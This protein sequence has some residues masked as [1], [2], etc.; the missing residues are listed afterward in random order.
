MC[1]LRK[2][3]IFTLAAD[4]T[5]LNLRPL[6]STPVRHKRRG[7]RALSFNET[8]VRKHHVKSAK[9]WLAART[10]A[11]A[12]RRLS[13]SGV[14]QPSHGKDRVILRAE[15]CRRVVRSNLFR[16]RTKSDNS[17]PTCWASWS[18]Q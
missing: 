13:D 11:S 7:H 10:Q 18:D 9:A 16:V 4:R 14:M 5:E 3:F 6:Q 2:H 8:R 1:K 17:A 12:S 15:N